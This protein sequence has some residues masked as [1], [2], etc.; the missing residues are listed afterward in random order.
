NGAERTARRARIPAL[1]AEVERAMLVLSTPVARRVAS[2]KERLLL[3]E[4]VETLLASKALVVDAC[5]RVVSD[6]RTV[7]SLTRRP[8]LFALARALGEAW[9]GDVTRDALVAR[10]FGSKLADESHR[11]RLRVE[12]GRLRRVLR[13]MADVHATK[14]GFELAPRHALEVV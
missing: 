13:T 4:E 9:P 8:V 14:L 5:R 12:V 7:V 10:A 3:L 11:A 6:P 2:G 1:T